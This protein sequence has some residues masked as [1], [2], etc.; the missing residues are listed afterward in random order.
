[1][2]NDAKVVIKEEH[3]HKVWHAKTSLK[4]Q[5]DAFFQQAPRDTFEMWSLS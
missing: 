3:F 5:W 4:R 2:Q 1:M